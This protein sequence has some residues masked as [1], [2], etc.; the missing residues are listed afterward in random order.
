MRSFNFLTGK[1]AIIGAV[2]LTLAS[3]GKDIFTTTYDGYT[4]GK[5]YMAQAAEGRNNFNLPLS[6]KPWTLGFGASYGGT[7]HAA[8]KDIPLEFAYKEDWIAG[9]NQ[10]HGTNY[11]SLP[12]GSYTISGLSSVIK[13]GKTSSDSL[14][15]TIDRKKLDL[16]KKYMFPITLIS[17][18]S[19]TI[20]S[21]LQTA[22]F[23]IDT[24]I[25]SERDIT[26]QGV[27]SVSNDNNGGPDAGEG[28]KKLVDNNIDTKFLVFN[29]NDYLPDFWYQLTFPTPK[30]LGAYTFTSG[31]DA[32]ERD[33]R[34]WEMQGSNNGTDW[35][36]LDT[37][38]GQT[39]SARK[40]TARYEFTNETP[41][42][43]YRVTISAINGASLFQQGEWRV[44]EFYEE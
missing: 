43:Y 8:D 40:M 7:M 26:G 11:I 3:C 37:K 15:I 38:S 4:N 18:P 13:K 36:V 34:D 22:W 44:I 29:I 41:Y 42:K 35:T 12:A 30:I 1:A 31:N 21:A 5:I 32:P 19:L 6:S 10:Q 2:F 20:D 33:P 14:S 39:F 27:I 24:I 28:S 16:E 17:A 25:R 23:R 9:Y